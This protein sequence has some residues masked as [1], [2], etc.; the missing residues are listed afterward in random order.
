MTLDEAVS[1]AC[2][3]VGIVPPRGRLTMRRWTPCDVVGKG[4]SGKGDGRIICDEA[5]ATAANWCTGETATV[6]L[7]QAW[8]PEQKR[9]YAEVRRADEHKARDRALEAGKIAER[10]IEAAK[11]SQHAYLIEKG[12]G[13]ELP[14]TISADNV[15]QIAGYTDRDGRLHPADYLVPEGGHRAIVIPARIGNRIASAQLIW[16]YGA[17]KFLAGGNM[18]GASHRIASGRETWLCEGYATGLSLRAALKGLGRRNTVLVCFSASNIA[19]V[20]E[21]ISGRC[22]I[23]ADHDAPPKAKPDQFGGLGA[24]EYFAR[25]SGCPYLMPPAVGADI[26]DMHQDDGIFAVQRLING[27]LR[28]AAM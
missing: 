25:K 28:E 26:N 23:A 21:T 24:G 17:K 1:Q 14:L 16:E 7:N 6:W 3:T 10:L 27:L 4:A 19:K 11:P 8:T 22:W 9:Q 18:S 20:A 12:F 15:R 13:A 5:R 2:A